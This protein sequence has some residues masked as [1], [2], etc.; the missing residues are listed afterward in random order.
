MIYDLEFLSFFNSILGFKSI[1]V[2]RHTFDGEILS[3]SWCF[4]FELTLIFV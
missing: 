1:S 4:E 3:G 2:V